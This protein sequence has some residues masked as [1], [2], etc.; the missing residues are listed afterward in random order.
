MLVMVDLILT[1]P[2]DPPAAV[3]ER[4]ASSCLKVQFIVLTVLAG[5]P[6]P[7]LDS[8]VQLSSRVK[9][10]ADLKSAATIAKNDLKLLQG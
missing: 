8:L 4:L 3:C 5:S 7:I 2:E 1:L 10:L 6:G 9:Q